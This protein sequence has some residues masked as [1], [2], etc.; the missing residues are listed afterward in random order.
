V[1]I[2]SSVLEGDVPMG[3]KG[4]LL[5]LFFR[6]GFF[7]S[8]ISRLHAIVEEHHERRNSSSEV[9]GY[10]SE[11]SELLRIYDP[12]DHNFVRLGNDHDGGYVIVDTLKSLD[13]VLSLGVG[14]DISFE[15]ALSV[16]VKRI[17]L[18]DHTVAELPVAIKNSNFYRLGIGEESNNNF[19]T[20]AH[21]T[22]LF[23]SNENILLKMDIESSEWAVLA[24]AASATLNRFQQIVV[25]FHGLLRLSES[26]FAREIIKALY[27]LNE[28]HKLVHLH[29]N[30]YEPIGIVG[31]VVVPNVLEA[32]YLKASEGEFIEIPRSRGQDLN[33]P[34][35]PNKLDISTSIRF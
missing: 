7:D 15:A 27:K 17:D 31:G 18:Y 14:S 8:Y 28:T 26:D 13:S 1:D 20:L 19:V 33:R 9:I 3:P 30:N 35:N 29:I 34:N 16:H 6:S 2:P 10:V 24:S 12:I 25:E 22:D 4:K 5:R 21:A 23:D 11:I 32:T